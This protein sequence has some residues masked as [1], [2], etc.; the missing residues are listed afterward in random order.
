MPSLHRVTMRLEENYLSAEG[1][2]CLAGFGAS[3]RNGC[4]VVDCDWSHGPEGCRHC[5]G[6]C[7]CYVEVDDDADEVPPC[8]VAREHD[9]NCPHVYRDLGECWLLP[10]VQEN[11]SGWME[12]LPAYPLIKEGIGIRV[13][14][15][16][17][18][19]NHPV[20]TWTLVFTDWDGEA[21]FSWWPTKPDLKTLKR[22]DQ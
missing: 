12:D 16:E 7:G 3:C 20:E 6:R 1:I 8:E 11:D 2:E 21:E 18:D 19:W 9:G 13:E 4:G 17:L 15:G 14:N 5:D 22:V 10:W